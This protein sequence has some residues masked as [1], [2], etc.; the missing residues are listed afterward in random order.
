MTIFESPTLNSMPVSNSKHGYCRILHPT[1]KKTLDIP[2]VYSESGRV[3]EI[4]ELIRSTRMGQVFHIHELVRIPGVDGFMRS[5]E[6]LA[7]KT[8]KKQAIMAMQMKGSEENPANEMM[9]LSLLSHMSPH[10]N[11]MNVKELFSDAENFYMVMPFMSGGDLLDVMENTTGENGQANC[12]SH[13]MARDMFSD[14]MSGL[15]HLHTHGIAHR[16]L[17]IENVLY[18]PNTESFSIIDLGMCLRLPKDE[19][20]GKYLPIRRR[21]ICGKKNYIAPEIWAELPVFH[22]MK[23]D[24]WAAGVM[25]FMVLTASAP[26]EQAVPSDPHFMAIAR[27]RIDDVYIASQR[28]Y[29]SEADANMISEEMKL[30]LDLVQQM[31]QVDPNKRPSIEQVLQHPYMTYGA[32]M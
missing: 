13:Q 32:A 25:L 18:N 3:Y 9:A 31:L 23:C 8:Y 10:S 11:V 6:D 7:V 17:S 30:A 16:D 19:T 28:S 20:S 29:R 15:Q 1:M 5:P 2:V 21:N 14:V 27:K 12:F 24:I 4:G 26:M 22:P